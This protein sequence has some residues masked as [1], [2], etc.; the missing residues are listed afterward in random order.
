MENLYAILSNRM[1]SAKRL[2][3]LGVGSFLRSDDAAGVLVTERLSKRFKGS[4]IKSAAFFTGE[5]APESMSGEIKRFKPDSLLVIDAADTG[6]E[7]GS[8]SLIEP[9][10]ITGVSFS[11][12]MLPIKI[13]LDYLEKETS[14]SITVI[15]IQPGRLAFAGKMTAKAAEAVDLVV[16]LLEESV[17]KLEAGI[18]N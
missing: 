11:T 6:D 8:V 17:L 18:H 4:G 7:P 3:I 14:C 12:H 10:A 2:A 13:M 15:G 9:G 5:S 1:N 16:S